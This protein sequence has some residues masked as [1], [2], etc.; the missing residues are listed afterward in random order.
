MMRRSLLIL[1]LVLHSFLLNG[2][3]PTSLLS[4]LPQA[5]GSLTG[6]G[7][8]TGN[9]LGTAPAAIGQAAPIAGPAIA[10]GRPVGLN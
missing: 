7:G 3:A 4:M 1:A 10:A 9:A 6:A 8:A 5:L 2:C